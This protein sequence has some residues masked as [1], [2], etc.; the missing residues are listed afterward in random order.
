MENITYIIPLHVFNKNVEQYLT[1]AVK[2]IAE[3]SFEQGD[4]ILLV[5]PKSVIDKAEAVCKANTEKYQVQKV[6]NKNTDFFT[7]VNTAAFACVTPYFTIIEYYDTLYPYWNQI[8][9]AYVSKS[10]FLI[11]LNLLK[12]NGEPFTLANEIA[13]STTFCKDEGIGILDTEALKD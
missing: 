2:S 11:S 4:R 6:E 12:K 13:L 9:Q 1:S 7:Q 8:M 5:G 10:P 3:N